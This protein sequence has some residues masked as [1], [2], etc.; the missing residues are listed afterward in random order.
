[1][2]CPTHAN[3]AGM[4]ILDQVGKKRLL[5]IVFLIATVAVLA[6]VLFS[7]PAK[8]IVLENLFHISSETT[9]TPFPVR[10]GWPASSKYSIAYLTASDPAQDLIVMQ[11]TFSGPL[12]MKND[13][14]MGDFIIDGDTNK[15]PIRIIIS[16][17]DSPV[18]LGQENDQGSVTFKSVT[19]QELMSKI[20]TDQRVELRMLVESLNSDTGS[21]Q[22][23]HMLF[24]DDSIQPGE[25]GFSSQMIKMLN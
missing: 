22:R 12:F 23:A 10:S 9:A 17:S 16:V 1:M 20:Q 4:S 2:N 3:V 11:G 24:D 18:S 6:T 5:I 13:V 8:K 7:T 15:S 19:A 25:Y 14:L 21:L